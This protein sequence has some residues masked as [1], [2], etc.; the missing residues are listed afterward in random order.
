MSISRITYVADNINGSDQ[1][2]PIDDWA[3]L[4]ERKIYLSEPIDDANA[5]IIT[6]KIDYL[7]IL[8]KASKIYV[9]FKSSSLKAANAGYRSGSSATIEMAGSNYTARIG[10]VLKVDDLEL[11]YY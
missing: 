9:S 4:K 2:I 10:S 11:I 6:M 5:H 7:N 8:A 3:L 1:L